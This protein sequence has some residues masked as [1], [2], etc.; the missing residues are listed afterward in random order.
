M[1]KKKRTKREK[2]S[3]KWGKKMKKTKRR[4]RKGIKRGKK[5][6]RDRKN[7]GEEPRACRRRR[8][9]WL[10]QR[11]RGTRQEGNYITV[12]NL[13]SAWGYAGGRKTW[14]N[15]EDMKSERRN[16][17]LWKVKEAE[18]GAGRKKHSRKR[19]WIRRK[20]ISKHGSI[21]TKKSRI[22]QKD[23]EKEWDN[24]NEEKRATIIRI[25][26]WDQT[27]DLKN[28]QRGI[29]EQPILTKIRWK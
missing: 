9:T 8:R 2:N 20:Y 3:E 26:K 11:R 10:R 27:R 1:A 6:S 18:D 17:G 16:L 25:I 21:Y 15:T 14:E 28:V 12:N 29:K 23:S 4:V 5:G 22:L 19:I 13:I 7:K 24:D